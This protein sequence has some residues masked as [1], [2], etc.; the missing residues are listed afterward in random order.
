[1]EE[2]RRLPL[3][4]RV[5]LAKVLSMVVAWVLPALVTTALAIGL[6]VPRPGE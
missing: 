4:R 6:A 5:L 1:M 2:T 3:W